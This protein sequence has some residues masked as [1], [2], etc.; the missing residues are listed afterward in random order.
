MN[1]GICSIEVPEI[2]VHLRSNNK[3]KNYFLG[4]NEVSFLKVNIVV[5]LNN[6]G[7]VVS[8]YLVGRLKIIWIHKVV[9]FDINYVTV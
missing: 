2:E 8:R 5:N 4:I 1:L 9:I 3:R 6:E 7:K